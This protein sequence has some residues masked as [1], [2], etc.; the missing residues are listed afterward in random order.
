MM[1][2]GRRKFIKRIFVLCA[3]A[4]VAAAPI[5]AYADTGSAPDMSAGADAGGGNYS[6]YIIKLKDGAEN[7]LVSAFSAGDGCDVYSG[8][9]SGTFITV[10]TLEEA[11]AVPEELIEYI[12]PDYEVELFDDTG[13][14]GK[15]GDGGQPEEPGTGGETGGGEGADKDPSS[16]AGDDASPYN[17]TYYEQYQWN[18]K[19][20]GA[21]EAYAAGLTG[22]GAKIAFVDSGINAAHEDLNASMISGENFN[23][24]DVPYDNDT[25]G[26]G[27]F[28]AGIVAAQSDN[29]L[30][31][32]GI[33][34]DAEIRAYRVFSEK[35]AKISTVT[36]GIDQAVEDGCRVIN[37]S[38]GTDSDSGT[39]RSTIENAVKNGVIVVAAVGNYGNTHNR[40][41]YPAG[42]SGVIGVGAIDEKL[43]VTAFSEKNDSVDFTAPGD[44]IP[45]L[46]NEVASGSGAYKLD[47]TSNSNRGTSYASPVVTGMAALALGYDSDITADTFFKLLQDTCVDRGEEG[48]DINYGYGTV[49]IAAFARELTR[50]YTLTF[51]TDGGSF[52]EGQEP[53]ASYKVTDDAYKLP[54]PSK[55][56]YIF[57]GWF[58][59]SELSGDPVEE[60]AAGSVGDR[61]YYA[62]WEYDTRPLLHVSEEHKNETGTAVPAAQDGSVAAKPYE[63]DVSKWF[64]YDGGDVQALPEDTVFKASIM[65][66]S[67]SGSLSCENGILKYVPAYSDAG[68]TVKIGVSASA[69]GRD[70][71]DS[72]ELSISVDKAPENI[73]HGGGGGS[74]GGGGGGGSAPASPAPV[75]KADIAYFADGKS[76]ENVIN[77]DGSVTVKTGQKELCVVSVKQEDAAPGSVAVA[78]NADGT[79]KVISDCASDDGRIYL[80]ASDGM[81]FKIEDRASD[82]NDI[83]KGSWKY[84]AAAF[85]SARGLFNGTGNGEFSPDRQMTR[86]M[87]MTVI[88]RMNGLDTSIDA[89]KDALSQ[90]MEWAVKNGI[91]DGTRAGAPITR[92]QLVT[93]LYRSAGEPEL[94]DGA[95]TALSSFKDS[96]SVSEYA[97]KAITWAVK[98]GIING[99]GDGTLAP[100]AGATRAQAAQMMLNYTKAELMGLQ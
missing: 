75:N 41:M 29:E 27:T 68:K 44:G 69:S 81:T 63:A 67:G 15:E 17:D 56:G 40:M 98:N 11:E 48:Y 52:A 83:E 90:G 89:S 57:K 7:K 18:L 100:R 51:E 93:M 16:D 42:Y 8:D 31:L 82:F 30:G 66:E 3:A 1:K 61:T 23:D 47:V 6:G 46:S 26:H 97:L 84:D 96:D 4:A 10:D 39:L 77:S 43:N 86:A 49:D 88:A 14:V 50:E 20:L 65:E 71:P 60:I 37:L 73:S 91:S 55:S 22:R 92:E 21:Y 70:C 53:A 24:D 80:K 33:A 72:V 59:N 58:E 64:A 35:N 5:G 94:D 79:E 34:P 74:G 25:Y 95:E 32:A 54:V 19:S 12:E 38:L 9:T 85:V 76:V 45:G 28:A 62:A 2:T 13:D 87:L 36:K 78:I 99:N